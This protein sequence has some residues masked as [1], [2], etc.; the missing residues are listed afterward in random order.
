MRGGGATPVSSKLS[1]SLG[2]RP[3]CDGDSQ[4]NGLEGP[5]QHKAPWSLHK[6]VAYLRPS[7]REESF[8]RSD[9]KPFLNSSSSCSLPLF[10]CCCIL[11]LCAASN[12]L[13]QPWPWRWRPS[14]RLCRFTSDY[15]PLALPP[16]MSMDCKLRVWSSLVRF[17]EWV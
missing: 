7:G 11:F 8:L 14:L 9:N 3:P 5:Q 2:A 1:W 12:L 10:C 4:I 15:H 16:L 17:A 13:Q 6:R